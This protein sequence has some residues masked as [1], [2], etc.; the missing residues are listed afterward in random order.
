MFRNKQKIVIS[1]CF[2]ILS[3]FSCNTNKIDIETLLKTVEYKKLEDVN[4]NLLSLDLYYFSKIDIKRPVVIYVH[5][6]A[7]SFGD[8]SSNIENKLNLFQSSN[9]I[10]VSINYRLSPF[11]FEI[12]NPD[13]IMYPAHN[14]DVADAIKWIYDNIDKYGGDKNKIALLGHSAGAHL[15]SLTGTNPN[16]L[17]DVGLSFSNIKGIASIDTEGYDVLAKIEENNNYYI[18][19]FGVNNTLNREASPIYNIVDGINYPKFFIAKRGN[20]ARIKIAN[21][22]INILKSKGVAVFEVDGSVYSHSEINEAIGKKD[23]K[24]ITGDLKQFFEECF[25]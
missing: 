16:F 23:E 15:V 3:I 12:Y 10:F 13:R 4:S 7:W 6:G 25:K 19:A 2:I 1:L 14:K 21:D 11:P 18:N 9:Y 20:S 22:F 5:G 24:V 17:N 8:K